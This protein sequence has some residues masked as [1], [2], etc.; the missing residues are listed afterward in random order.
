MA[1]IIEF[2]ANEDGHG[3][4]DETVNKEEDEQALL[5]AEVYGKDHVDEEII[6]FESD[7]PEIKKSVEEEVV[8]LTLHEKAVEEAIL[9]EDVME[10]YVEVSCHS[11][12]SCYKCKLLNQP[13]F[14]QENNRYE[15]MWNNCKAVEQ[16]D[17]TFKIFVNYQF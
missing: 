3:M 12:S 6:A 17:G 13:N 10:K 2:S 15:S 16:Q 4:S 1:N 5:V 14:I 9:K 11:A 7:M 8:M